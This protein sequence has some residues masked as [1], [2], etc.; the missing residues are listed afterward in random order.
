MCRPGNG[1]IFRKCRETILKREHKTNMSNQEMRRI[2]RE[3][4]CFH[5]VFVDKPPKK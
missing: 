3:F 1:T 2:L 5:P 4:V